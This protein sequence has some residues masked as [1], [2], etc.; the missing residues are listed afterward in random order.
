MAEAFAAQD[1]ESILRLCIKTLMNAVR[2]HG[3]ELDYH[4]SF[5][6]RSRMQEPYI[7]AQGVNDK[8]SAGLGMVESAST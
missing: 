5:C 3:L 1:V 8:V 2:H 6:I 4:W 7:L